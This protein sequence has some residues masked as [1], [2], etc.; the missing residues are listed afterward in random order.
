[1]TMTLFYP[2]AAFLVSA[3]AAF[4]G[5]PWLLRF[6]QRRGLYDLPNERKIHHNKIPRL[7]GA[8]F[9]PC[10]VMG[11]VIAFSLMQLID[12]QFPNITLSTFIIF[13]GIF[14]I[15]LVG[16][17]DD[18]LGLP[19]R[20][21]FIIQFIASLFLPL[22]NLYINNLYGFLGIYEIPMWIGYPLT[23]LVCLLVV[24]SINLIDGID[25]LASGLSMMALLAFSIVFF[26]MQVI[27]YAV[28]SLALIGA[29]LVFFYYNM[30][31]KPEKMTKTFMGDT[32]SLILG[33]AL[34]YLSIKLAMNNDDILPYW[35]AALLTS[36]SLL[37]V[38]T[39]DLIRVAIGRLRKRTS[40][41]HADK[42][43]I[44]HKFLAAGWSM[45]ATLMAILVLQL[46]FCGMNFGLYLAGVEY[47]WIVAADVV[48]FAGVHVTLNRKV[49]RSLKACS[50]MQVQAAT[51][52]EYGR[53][54]RDK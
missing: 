33:Y 36:Y 15:Y 26:R 51:I 47:T 8:L 25:G 21:K 37:L 50:D 27:T 20:I 18:V 19:A 9:M 49:A 45:H 39:F 44:H 52:P 22:C 16:L 10:A 6:C 14:L 41:F 43:H 42:T 1:M 17:L 40:I 48:L 31:G 28:F 12:G 46:F 34:S 5:M 29:V 4:W 3:L 38:P 23:I 53:K 30:F 7:G 32:G 35:P 2:L 54:H 24:N 11:M 13:S